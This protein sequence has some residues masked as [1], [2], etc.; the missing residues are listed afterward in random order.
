MAAVALRRL[1]G[2]GLA[3]AATAAKA[4]AP[5]QAQEPLLSAWSPSPWSLLLLLLSLSLYLSGVGRLWRQAGRGRGI[6]LHQVA[7]F[8]GGWLALV[9][10]VESPLEVLG[11]SLFSAHMLQHELLMIVA[12]PL[13]VMGRPLAAAVWAFPANARHS[14]SE[15]LRRTGLRAAWRLLSAPMVAWA[16]HGVVLWAW[17]LPS[18]FEAALAQPV[19]H[20]L[21]HLCFLWS[22]LLFWWAPLGGSRQG[23]GAT[24]A[25]L[26]TTM[27]HTGA[28]GALLTLAPTPWYPYYGDR[29]ALLGFDP[30]VDQQLGGLVMWVPGGLAYLAVGLWVGARFLAAPPISGARGA[31]T[32]SS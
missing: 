24:L 30:L 16:L 21:Q 26:F 31:S 3:L 20:A 8:V 28:L 23:R 14:L 17:H 29:A 7:A 32:T 12:A 11:A 2:A 27:L 4:H 5:L 13:L 25:Y 6:A 22:A 9:L 10:A 18:L 1:S 19:L 15:A